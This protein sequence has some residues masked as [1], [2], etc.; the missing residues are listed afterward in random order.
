MPDSFDF[1]NSEAKSY[2]NSSVLMTDM[3]EYTMLD[4]SLIH[5]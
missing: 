3:Y 5:I 4:L 1:V 2:A